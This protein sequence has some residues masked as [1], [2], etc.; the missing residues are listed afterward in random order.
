MPQRTLNISL[1][2]LDG[3]TAFKLIGLLDHIVAQLWLAY[4]DQIVQDDAGEDR[5]S[6]QEEFPF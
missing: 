2:D 6:L 1:P 4:G 3:E 5:P